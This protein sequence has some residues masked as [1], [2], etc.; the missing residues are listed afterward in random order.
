MADN[1]TINRG[2]D[3]DTIATDDISG[4]KHQLVKME[5]GVA[6]TATEVSSTDPLPVI[7][8]ASG[9]SFLQDVESHSTLEAILDELRLIN[10][11]LSVISN[12]SIEPGEL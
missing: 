10:F 6:N 3:G 11:H 2:T 9:S 12:N 5:F 1:T 7:V 8:S 4:V